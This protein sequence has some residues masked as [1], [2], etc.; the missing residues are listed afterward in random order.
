MTMRRILFLSFITYL[1]VQS[2]SKVPKIPKVDEGKKNIPV[3]EVFGYARCSNCPI[4]DHAVDSLKAL[5]KD[6]IAV[7]EYHLQ[8]LGDT[9][10]PEEIDMKIDLYD[11]GNSVPSTIIQGIYR[12]DGAEDTEDKQ[13]TKFNSYYKSLRLLRDSVGIYMSLDTIN[14]SIQITFYADSSQYIDTLKD[15]LFVIITEDSVL[16]KQ[17]GASDSIFNNVVRYIT[18]LPTTLPQSLNFGK[19]YLR[20]KCVIGMVQDTLNNNIIS[21]IQRRF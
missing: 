4:V 10:S 3:F 16:F 2:C 7:L 20:K 14:D 11:I 21:T 5:Y 19:A 17:S 8:N 1:V 9:L 13:I 6:S 12:I 15:V 18:L